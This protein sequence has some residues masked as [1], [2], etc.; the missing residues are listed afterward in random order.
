[1]PKV[2]PRKIEDKISE[3]T[4]A[5]QELAGGKSFG[6]MTLPQFQAAVADSLGT[7]TQIGQLQQQLTAAMDQRD[8][9]D[10]VSLEKIQLVVNGVLADPTEGPNSSLYEG[11]GYT[12]KSERASGLTRKKSTPS[13]T[14]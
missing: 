11:M 9:A 10:R 4:T 6:G 14:P 5:W 8:D 3:M 1:M 13:P 7:R 2:T 12:R